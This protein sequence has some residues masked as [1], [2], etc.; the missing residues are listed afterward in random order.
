VLSKVDSLAVPRKSLK[1]QIDEHLRFVDNYERGI[2][3]SR[4]WEKVKNDIDYA[5]ARAGKMSGIEETIKEKQEMEEKQEEID[6][7]IR[8][9]KEQMEALDEE[10]E[11]S[12]E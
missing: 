5:L 10:T 12:D 7:E 1:Q 11:E 6:E 3:F 4:T 2:L 9:L 8:R